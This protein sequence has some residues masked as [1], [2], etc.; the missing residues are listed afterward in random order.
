MAT[1]TF[2]TDV[3]KFLDYHDVMYTIELLVIITACIIN[4]IPVYLPSFERLSDTIT[5]NMRYLNLV[6]K[7]SMFFTL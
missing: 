1:L 2:F 3:C 4:V 7:L 6:D 5:N